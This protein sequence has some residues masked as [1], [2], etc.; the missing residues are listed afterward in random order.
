MG[1]VK[2]LFRAKNNQNFN[3]QIGS[4]ENKKRKIPYEKNLNFE[5][6]KDDEDESSVAQSECGSSV[7]SR[8]SS[9]SPSSSVLTKNHSWASS[10]SA[11]SF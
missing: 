11:V 3:K 9:E 4:I 1:S 10:K 8:Q 7:R 2:H 6:K 5:I